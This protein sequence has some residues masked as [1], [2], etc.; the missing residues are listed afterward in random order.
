MKNLKFMSMAVAALMLGAC[1][2]SEDIADGTSEN[3]FAENGKGYVSVTLNL[4][5]T[6]S[7]STRAANDNYDDGTASEY[8]VKNAMLIIFGCS[9]GEDVSAAKYIAAYDLGLTAN[10]ATDADNDN[11]TTQL[12]K[13]QEINSISTTK[14]YALVVLNNNGVVIIDNGTLKVNGTEFKGT[15]ADFTAKTVA[16]AA[17]FT[18]SGIFMTNAPLADMPGSAV[19]TGATTTIL[20]EIS[21]YIYPTKAQAETY[22]A[23]DI[24]V[25]RAVAKVSID[26]SAV[27]DGK[28]NIT[29]NEAASTTEV[30]YTVTGWQ[31]ANINDKSYLVRNWNQKFDEG[32]T[33]STSGNYWYT[34]QSD[35]DGLTKSDA[36]GENPYRFAG[37]KMVKITD[38]TAPSDGSV[39][40]PTIPSTPYRT[41]FGMD[42]NYSSTAGFDENDVTT[43]Y[44]L[45]AESPT[46]SVYCLE[47]TFN[48][49]NQNV[50]NTTCMI[51][52]AKLNLDATTF[53]NNTFYTLNGSTDAI[54]SKT[55]ID[56]KVY[57]KAVEMFEDEIIASTGT[58]L[59]R[60]QI[61]MDEVKYTDATSGVDYAGKMIIYDVV[62][63][64]KNSAT[65]YSLR[66]T[67]NGE[68]II[69][70]LNNNITVE[71]YLNGES[72][73]TVLLKHFGDELTPWNASNSKTESYPAASADKNWLGRYGLLRNNWYEVSVTGLQAIGSS[74]VPEVW[75]DPTPDDNLKSYIS[76]SINVLSWAK[77]TQG[78]ILGE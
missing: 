40:D 47:N 72:Y 4:P 9:E 66:A 7:S 25:E 3:G 8:E 51:V 74:T 39:N 35:G 26:V 62:A 16:S 68:A 11:I 61:E 49:A 65:T 36:L 56:N 37:I 1:S 14:K 77:R 27:A 42:P 63:K 31:L 29:Q 78:V 60:E 2:S 17:S 19:M 24:V 34:L 57:E 67:E 28:V 76:V 59:T 33:S 48:V 70:S 55:D 18:E 52:K 15:F 23:A 71:K 53:P 50:L 43:A 44:D 12:K 13:T 41:Y 32:V 5:T 54:Y 10:T 21:N 58:S 22:A 20:P 69:T 73:Y 75:K 46:T 30:G 38:N 64:V 6:S 45:T